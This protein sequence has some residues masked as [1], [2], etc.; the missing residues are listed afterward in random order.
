[1]LSDQYVVNRGELPLTWTLELAVKT[2]AGLAAAAALG[3]EWGAA[4]YWH[5]GVP[6][7]PLTWTRAAR[8]VLLAATMLSFALTIPYVLSLVVAMAS[9]A[10]R[11]LTK[12]RR[13]KRQ[14]RVF[15]ILFRPRTVRGLVARLGIAGVVLWLVGFN[16]GGAYS[17]ARVDFLVVTGADRS[18]PFVVLGNIGD[19]LYASGFDQKS[20][21]LTNQIAIFAAGDPDLRIRVNSLGPLNPHAAAQAP[22]L[23]QVFRAILQLERTEQ[24]PHDAGR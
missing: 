11:Q 6:M 22:L 2:I 1:M 7:A 19:S 18:L 21:R 5:L 17:G 4:S 20:G 3:F 8:D 9:A 14:S 23:A 13:D 15:R 12:R 10:W 16:L 24:L